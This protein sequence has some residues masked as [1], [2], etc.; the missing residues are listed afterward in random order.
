MLQEDIEDRMRFAVLGDI[1]G[2]AVALQAVLE[3]L[4]QRYNDVERV[5]ATGDLVGRGPQ[6]NEVVAMLRDANIES[7]RGNYDDAVVF[8]RMSSGMDFPDVASEDTDARALQWTRTVL[9][10]ENAEHLRAL[11]R[12]MRLRPE[13]KGIGVERVREDE[14]TREYRRTFVTRALFGGLARET[15]R[16]L[17]KTKRVLVVHGSPRAMNE[18][19]R[20]ETANSMLQAMTKDV[21]ADVVITG[22]A[23]ECFQRQWNEV[24]F[25][26]AGSVS[27]VPES[28]P[29]ARYAVVDVTDEVK[30]QFHEITYDPSRHL[31]ALRSSGL[32][33]M[34]AQAFER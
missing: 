29:T 18:F 17:T 31:N 12:E 24:D 7:V 5:I 25:V 10:T 2:N 33:H 14:R 4:Q 27:G 15:K 9:T 1:Q 19:I 16:P 8:E 3:D 11:P 34:L 32:P 6:P 30:A 21:A 13:F 26:G 28:G 23:G 20:A 22:H